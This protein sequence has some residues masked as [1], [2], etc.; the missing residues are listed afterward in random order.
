MATQA[1]VASAPRQ[2]LLARHPL[3]SFFVMAF[4]FSWIAWAP[5]NL[6]ED[7]HGLLPY[8]PSAALSGVFLKVG[9]LLGPFMSAFIWR[10]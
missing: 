10:T 4:A 8:Y 5:W 9:L 2:N 1:S 7:G 3:V 6:S